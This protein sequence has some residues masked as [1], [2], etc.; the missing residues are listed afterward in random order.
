MEF[1]KKS[2]EKEIGVYL[3]I[4]IGL[5]DSII[6]E[7]AIIK[8]KRERRHVGIS[9]S[10]VFHIQQVKEVNAFEFIYH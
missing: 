4:L 3:F 8:E 1:D 5:S 6:K 7:D 2:Y 10:H 9:V